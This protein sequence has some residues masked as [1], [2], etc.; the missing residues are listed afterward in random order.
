MNI[1]LIAIGRLENQYAHEW[2]AHHLALGFDHI[3]IAD[4]NHDGEERFES[5]LGDFVAHG[6]VII[7]DYR[8][9]EAAQRTA[10]NDLYRIYSPHYDWLAFFD[11]DEFLCLNDGLTSVKQLIERHADHADCV[12]VPWMMMTDNNLVRYDARPLM[13]RFTERSADTFSAGKCIVRG[14]ITDLRFTK[15][16]HVPYQPILRCV[17][18]TGAPT[19]QH[20]SQPEEYSVAYLKHF[21]TKTVEE[22]LINKM[23]KGTAGRRYENFCKQYKYYFFMINKKTPEKEQF[24]NDFENRRLNVC[25]VH[26]NT[27]K[28]TACTVRS[29]L[30]CN[31][32][33]HIV[34]FDNSDKLPFM[35][36]DGV[37]I[38]DNTSGQLINFKTWLDG[39]SDKMPTNNDWASAK[40]CYTIQWLIDH[41][42]EPFILMDSDVLVRRDVTELWDITQAFVGEVRMHKSYYIRLERVMPFICFINVPMLKSS[43]VTYYNFPKM[44]AL[45][46]KSPDIGYDTGAWFLEDCKNHSLPYRTVPIDPYILHLKSGSWQKRNTEAWLAEN[47]SLWDEDKIA[48]CAIGRMEND[49]AREFVSHY[50]TIGF[51]H[52]FLYDNA[53]EGEELLTDALGDFVADG[54]VTII[55][56][57]VRNKTQKTAYND[58]YHRYGKDYTWMA[59]FDFDEFLTI[60]S[61]EDIHTFMQRYR[62]YQCLLVNWKDY[63][64]GNML[65]S[66]GRPLQERFTVPMNLD[67]PVGYDFPENNHVKSIV[68]TGISGFAFRNPHIPQTPALRCCNT[69]GQPC[70]QTPWI[71]YDHSIAYIKHYTTKTIGE[72][73]N[74]KW[75]KGVADRS[76]ENF[77]KTYADFFFKVNDRTPEKEQYIRDWEKRQDNWLIWI[78]YHRDE[79]VQQYG[80]REDFHH[81]LFPVHRAPSAVPAAVSAVSQGENTNINSLNTCFSEFVTLWY[82]WHNKLK[83]EYVG[84]NHYRRQFANVRLPR[85]NECQVYCHMTDLKGHLT[86]REHFARC[87]NI[88]DLDLLLTIID[89]RYGPDNAYSRYL[90]TSTTMLPNVCFLMAWHDY[91]Q[92]GDFLFPLLDDFA[93]A[94]GCFDDPDKWHAKAVADFGEADAP[95]QQ[96]LPGFLAERLVSAW[97][98]INL[99]WY[100]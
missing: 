92:M 8:N 35:P 59:F 96:R 60:V 81:H 89:R 29:L 97:I 20:R 98:S 24:V 3:I 43:G 14:G 34:V 15:S 17:T 85:E 47:R 58:C 46:S 73:L 87:H 32:N 39:F 16:V 70:E 64:D 37:E 38:I 72:W 9:R 10:Y 99:K 69:K 86:I 12:M 55:P 2:V 21:S 63:T 76:H 79:Q 100:I 80:L 50:I 54:K 23:K 25:I 48:L 1:A 93:A 77:Q 78:T 82:V 42:D 27:P 7:H 95:Y 22:W 75:Q 74:N 4:N 40:H 68:H 28:L 88:K 30:K 94:T 62:D 84:F 65:E 49:Y 57:P 83:T 44:Y 18:P 36:M 53:Q 41:T 90:R 45:T 51:D 19:R 26:Y 91:M 33:A 52:L 6:K 56:F 67:K 5:V 11:F 61:G 71:P 31:P 13:E 66:D